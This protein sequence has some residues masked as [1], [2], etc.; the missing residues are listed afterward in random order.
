VRVWLER[1]EIRHEEAENARVLYVALTRA[2]ERLVLL[3]GDAAR[4]TWIQ[5]LAPWGYAAGAPPGD[6]ELLA[7]DGV[8]HRLMEEPGRGTRRPAAARAGPEPAVQRFESAV[9]AMRAASA[10]AFRAPSGLREESLA[11][12][13]TE[14]PEDSPAA[15]AS[16]E[17]ARV[18]G[19][20]AHRLLETWEGDDAD[21][22][23]SLPSAGAAFALKEGAEAGAVEE[24]LRAVMESFLSSPL[25]G[26][27]RDILA[28]EALLARELPLLLRREEDR[29]TA[30]FRGFVDLLYRD[31]QGRVVVADYK[32]DLGLS[33]EEA[34]DHYRAQLTVYAEA[35][36]KGL[37]LDTLPRT[38]LWLLR[39]GNTVP[40]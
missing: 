36:M 29:G 39:T 12:L 40:L 31:E 35:V 38:E 7:G 20:A 32:T 10:P 14:E 5:A 6:G 9:G 33:P 13:E 26:L 18:V 11:R 15:A 1:E 23:A 34:A 22:R 19:L 25:A 28:R 21:L 8:R 3:A 24:D 17:L 27:F 2:R 30:R 16:P 4:A 37:S